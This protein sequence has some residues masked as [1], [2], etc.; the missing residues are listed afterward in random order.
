MKQQPNRKT[1]QARRRRGSTVLQTAVVLPVL[2]SVSMGAVEFGQFL[3]IRHAFLAAARDA[4]RAASLPSA[5]SPTV[6]AVATST[7]AQ[8]NVTLDSSWYTM[9]D[10]S[11]DGTVV[12]PVTDVTTIPSGDRVQ[13]II[14]TTYG[15]IPNAF[16][17]LYQIFGK[18]IGSN[19][20]MLGECTVVKE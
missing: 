17:P 4:A 9:N 19:K 5:T 3:Y 10:V 15:Q 12:T 6:L 11:S 1:R 7:R 20:P 2:L 18:G 13:I 16:R 8:A 14:S